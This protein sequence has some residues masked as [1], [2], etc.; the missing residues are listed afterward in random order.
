MHT[1]CKWGWILYVLG[2]KARRKNRECCAFI[3]LI[4]LATIGNFLRERHSLLQGREAM[5]AAAEASAGTVGITQEDLEIP[6]F[7]SAEE[8]FD[9]IEKGE[10]RILVVI[11]GTMWSPVCRYTFHA[12]LQ[13]A[14]EEKYADFIRLLFIDQDKDVEFC[15]REGIP[16]GFPTLI[17]FDN[18]QIIPF[19]NEGQTFDPSSSDQRSRLIQQLNE[20]QLRSLFD[21]A[22]DVRN[23][24]TAAITVSKL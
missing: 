6:D 21:G 3:I 24:H 19:L 7:I 18:K 12:A 11:M 23:E 2:I 13:V 22:L 20:K 1:P 4:V 15:F 14:K 10:K 16:V 17:I 5:A 8:M 9:E